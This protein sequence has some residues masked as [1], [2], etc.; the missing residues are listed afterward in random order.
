[1]MNS[2]GSFFTNLTKTLGCCSSLA[3][4]PCIGVC[5]TTQW[6]DDRCKGCG[7]TATEVKD[8]GTYSTVEKKL[9][10]LRNAA[11][12]YPIRQVKRQNRVRRTQKPVAAFS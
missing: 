6:G 12:K 8:W 7:R 10:N 9:I 2:E 1:M 4:C 11:E 3:D 5:S